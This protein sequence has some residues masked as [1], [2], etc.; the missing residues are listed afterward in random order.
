[1][2]YAGVGFDGGPRATPTVD[3]DRVYVLGSAGML[4]CLNAKTG[5]I[6][7]KQDYQKD[8]GAQPDKWSFYFGF[9][10]APLVDGDRLI[11][12]V[13]GAPDAKVVAFDKM[14]GKELWR[15]LKTDTEPGFQPAH[16]HRRGRTRQ[17]IVWHVGGVAS[18]ARP[19][20]GCIGS[21]RSRSMKRR[22]S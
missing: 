10:S 18:S 13:G 5:E 8:L 9:S 19:V 6:L 21:S 22:R 14:T 20:A 4:L 3:G 7:W 11:C 16:H 2:S 1:V 15:A 12:I 17:L